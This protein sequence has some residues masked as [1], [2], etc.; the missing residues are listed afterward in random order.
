MVKSVEFSDNPFFNAPFNKIN[1]CQ[2]DKNRN[3]FA[4]SHEISYS[5]KTLFPD[6]VFIRINFVK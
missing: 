2:T 1:Y 3:D 6:Y 5:S 4:K